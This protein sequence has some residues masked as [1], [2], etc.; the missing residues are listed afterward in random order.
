MQ[1]SSTRKRQYTPPFF[2]KGNIV[3]R[4]LSE[5]R[6]DGAR[7]KS[8]TQDA[9]V[10]YSEECSKVGHFKGFMDAKQSI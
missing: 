6:W 8:R 3:H 2:L 5:R 9:F 4:P 7:T 10:G 1:D